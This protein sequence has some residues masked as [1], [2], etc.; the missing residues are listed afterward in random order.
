MKLRT[1]FALIAALAALP[2]HA[3]DRTHGDGDA[4]FYWGFDLGEASFGLNR[5]DLDDQLTGALGEAGIDVLDGRSGTSEDG[6]TWG[7]TFG[8]QFMRYLAVEAAYVD[9]GEAEYT[10]RAL[11]SDG[12]TTAD[13]TA[14]FT[15]DSAGPA[16]SVLGTLP[17]RSGWDVHAR[18]GMYFGSNDTSTNLSVDDLSDSFGDS[19]SS[20]SFLWG[21]GIGYTSGQ[22]TVRLDYQ[23]FTDVGD[24]DG[25]G[26][27][28][29][30]RLTLGAVYRTGYGFW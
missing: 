3:A 10:S 26:E 25:L 14:K 27:V 8:Y 28:D 29:V 22:W 6:F 20:Q 4:G 21:A 18:A 15:T 1:G 9:L 7:L 16:I 11:V 5:G 12:A 19:S 30:D 17:I 13:V 24:E 23:Q 2:V